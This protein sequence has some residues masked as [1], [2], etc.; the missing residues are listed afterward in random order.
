MRWLALAIAL[1]LL[2]RCNPRQRPIAE[3]LAFG[4]GGYHYA[5]LGA[6]RRRRSHDDSRCFVEKER[7]DWLHDKRPPAEF[8]PPPAYRRPDTGSFIAASGQ[9][10]VAG[11]IRRYCDG[12]PACEF[13]VM[14]GDNIYPDGATAG[15]D[16]RD[17][18]E[19]FRQ[20][21]STNPT[22][23]SPRFS[24]DFRIYV[25]LGNHDWRTSR[26]GAMAQVHY[27][28]TRRPSTWTT[29]ATG[30]RRPATRR[31]SRSSCSIR[32]CSSPA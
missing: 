5:Y 22:R 8:K 24:E 6:G 10:A 30:W 23:L 18:A 2:P 7:L 11:A 1:P 13:A 29:S 16:G 14:L 25:A 28:E 32:T 4:D 12:P 19:R 3:F 26:E 15:A 9:A 17:D 21:S 27:H 20:A 31:K